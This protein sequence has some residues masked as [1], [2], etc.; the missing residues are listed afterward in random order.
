MKTLSLLLLPV[1]IATGALRTV[2][3]DEPL[4]DEAILDCLRIVEDADGHS[5]LRAG[6]DLGSGIVGKVPAGGPVF[7]DPEPANGFH[8]VF[9]D[10]E[11]GTADRYLHAS[12]LRPVKGW[13]AFG[14]GASRGV[15]EHGGFEAV[16]NDPA[17]VA[18]DHRVTRDAAGIVRVDGKLPWGQDGG[19]PERLL[20]LGITIDGRKVELPAEATDNL[21]EPNPETLVLLTPGDPSDQAILLMAN[22]G[23]G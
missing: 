12:R 21:Y 11:D 8:R 23:S 6:A 18:A 1:V 7:V 5:N 13:K 22:G 14:P 10:K 16:V 19:E 9:L 4:V 17:F 2:S 15:L 20:K 3:A